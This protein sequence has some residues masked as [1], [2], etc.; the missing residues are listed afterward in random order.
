MAGLLL[1]AST[2]LGDKPVATIELRFL[3]GS[4]YVRESWLADGPRHGWLE[5]DVKGTP[6]SRLTHEI[7]AD[8]DLIG[9]W[10]TGTKAIN[11]IP[12]VCAAKPGLVSPLDLP[13]GRMLR[14]HD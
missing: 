7:Y 2:T 1:K 13:L 5:V 10:S 6:G 4:E 12:F 14:L 11:A 8:D 3:L 9:T